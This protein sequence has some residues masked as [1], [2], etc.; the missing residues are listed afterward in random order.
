MQKSNSLIRKLH[1]WHFTF[2]KRKNSISLTFNGINVNV[3]N[4]SYVPY[5][6]LQHQNLNG[7]SV[8]C[9]LAF[10]KFSLTILRAKSVLYPPERTWKNVKE[11]VMRE[12]IAGKESFYYESENETDWSQIIELHFS[13]SRLA[14]EA[15]PHSDAL[16]GEGI[17]TLAWRCEPQY[18]QVRTSLRMSSALASCHIFVSPFL[19][20]LFRQ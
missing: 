11:A 5:P 1:K 20:R 6:V 9:C 10:R 4:I 15:V 3:L 7:T 2:V 12:Q 8:R 17:L 19:R 13:F 14:E 18:L 16:R